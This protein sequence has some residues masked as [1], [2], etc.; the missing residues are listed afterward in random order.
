MELLRSFHNG[1]KRQWELARN[2]YRL[3]TAGRRDGD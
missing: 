3:G 2:L 1:T